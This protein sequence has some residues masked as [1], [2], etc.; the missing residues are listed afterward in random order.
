MSFGFFCDRELY[1]PA[2]F[3]PFFKK[4]KQIAELV[5]VILQ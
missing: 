3:F 2:F 4:N 5:C 1:N